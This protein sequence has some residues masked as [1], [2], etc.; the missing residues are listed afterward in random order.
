MADL[1]ITAANVISD[2]AASR[3][4]GIAGETVSA[5]K[6]AYL[7]PTSKKWMLADSNAATV[8]AHHTKGIF[9]NGAALNQPVSVHLG[10][11]ITIGAT[12]TPG[13]RYYQ[14]ETP[15]G[16]QPEGDLG[17]G[18]D[19]CLIGLATSSSVLL[20]DFQYPGVTL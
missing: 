1:S 14:S 8:A 10:G 9:L 18:E 20:V 13:A 4:S 19:I 2:P 11:P 6:T 12:L 15:G 17:S 7:D 16:I 3:A 5:G